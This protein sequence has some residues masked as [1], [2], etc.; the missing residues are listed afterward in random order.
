MS[1]TEA[2]Y[3]ANFKSL[4]VGATHAQE[5]FAEWFA[6]CAQRLHGA[7]SP[8]ARA[9]SHFFRTL[10]R[11]GAIASRSTCVEDYGTLATDRWRLYAETESGPWYRP[12]LDRRMAI[13]HETAKSVA[14]AAFADDDVPPDDIIQVSCT[15]Y[16]SPSAIQELVSLR[17]WGEESRLLGIG[18]M[19]CY[20]AIP[21]TR[22]AGLTAA[23]GNR[24]SVLHTELCS[25][26]LDLEAVEPEQLVVHHLFADGAIR[27]DVAPA[28]AATTPRF[29]LLDVFE[30]LIPDSAHAMT[31]RLGA[32]GFRMSLMR[33][34][35]QAVA[36]AV[37][38]IVHKRLARLG[39]RHD[40]VRGWA[41]HPGG[42]R[43]L[44][45]LAT[46]LELTD[47]D[48]LAHSRRVLRERG[49]MSSATLPHIWQGMLDDPGLRGGDLVV[50]LAFGPG[51][52]VA[53]NVLRKEV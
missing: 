23:S 35:P 22:V 28:T 36:K 25:L 15:G 12:S 8:R 50:S 40:L 41:I 7:R 17:G 34:V 13:F 26:H 30:V 44:S 3:L 9:A 51:L 53:G 38:G 27:Y 52:T 32:C 6:F 1:K 19:G 46:C 5:Q 10:N 37:R 39:L 43:I 2:T 4:P 16:H 33:H 21:A 49:N 48:A 20:G 31:W 47:P 14:L 18:H 42:P 45:E 11:S 24:C 29:E